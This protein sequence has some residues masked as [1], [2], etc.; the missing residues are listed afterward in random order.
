MSLV[1]TE[2]NPAT[3]WEPFRPTTKKAW[4]LARAAHL[5]RRAA[6][7][8]SWKQLQQ[9][10]ADGPEATV[11]RLLTGEPDTASFYIEARSMIA[12]L[13]GL[14]GAD[15]LPAWWLYVMIHSPHPLREHATLFWHGHFATSAAKVTDRGLMLAQNELF[16]QH[17]L[18]NFGAL[19]RS[20]AKDPAML[21]WLDS[22]VNRKGR[23]NENFAREVM[24]L[25]SLGVGNYTER[26]IKEAARAFTGW[27]VHHNQFWINAAQHDEGEKRVLGER[28][29]FDGDQIIDLLLRQP[30]AARYIV[31]KLY[32]Y[33][34]ADEFPESA[35][36][37]EVA[38][39]LEP[40]AE[41]LREHDYDV[42]RVVRRMLTSNWFYAEGAMAR[43]IKGPVEFAVGLVRSLEGHVDHYALSRDLAQL[44]QRVFFPPNVKGWNGG[45]EWINSYTL[46]SRTNLIGEM[47]SGSDG[48]YGDKLG[49]AECPALADCR[50]ERSLVQRLIDLTLA[51]APPADVVDELERVA[52][53]KAGESEARRRGRI[54]HA[55]AALPEFQLA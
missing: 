36:P 23:A 51:V 14:G 40:L 49:L 34:V 10:V 5:Y 18:G 9:A 21:L 8:G 35:S 43:R 29:A 38:A 31:R 48:R 33:F 11:D 55:L 52:V 1:S 45:R 44:G 7:G 17:A 3:A 42:A 19:L 25:F 30:A 37:A 41:E 20:E 53:R 2:L 15:D 50:D 22:A 27:E 28:G 32:R 54:V 39:F 6:F 4:N 16:R 46:V 13:L 26:D 24:E 12:S 47:A